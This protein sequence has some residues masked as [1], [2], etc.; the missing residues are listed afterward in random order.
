MMAH[1]AERRACLALIIYQRGAVDVRVSRART[2]DDK[3]VWDSEPSKVWLEPIRLW[4]SLLKQGCNTHLQRYGIVACKY[5]RFA[6]NASR[7]R[8]NSQRGAKPW[9][10]D[11]GPNFSK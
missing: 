6:K 10:T 7:R 2:A 5:V 9:R 11:A 4:R 8:A 1:N 3:L